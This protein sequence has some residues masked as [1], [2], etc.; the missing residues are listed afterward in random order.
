MFTKF[1]EPLFVC[2]H[3]Q[4]EQRRPTSHYSRASWC[5]S[6]CSSVF[7]RL[8]SRAP[9]G[10]AYHGKVPRHARVHAYSSNWC[11]QLHT[12]THRWDSQYSRKFHAGSAAGLLHPTLSFSVTIICELKVLHSQHEFTQTENHHLTDNNSTFLMLDH[13]EQTYVHAASS[14][15]LNNIPFLLISN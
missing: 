6:G 9:D 4:Q 3:N 12:H 14:S 7:S 11:N 2:Q 5:R 13:E 8:D 1:M 15:Q 10:T